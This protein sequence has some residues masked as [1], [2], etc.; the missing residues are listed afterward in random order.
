MQR[1][2]VAGAAHIVRLHRL[3]PVEEAGD[4]FQVRMVLAADDSRIFAKVD[5]RIESGALALR[6][7][8]TDEVVELPKVTDARRLNHTARP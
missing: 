6:C 7:L 5:A 2:H 4:P 1:A 3:E 8:G